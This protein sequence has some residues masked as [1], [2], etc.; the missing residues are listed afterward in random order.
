MNP[1]RT[2]FAT[3]SLF[4]ASICFAQNQK[5]EATSLLGQPLYRKEFAD[6]ELIKLSANLAEAQSNYRVAPDSANNVIW[7]GRRLG[8]VWCFREAITA[9]SDGIAKHPENPRLYRHRGH[10]YIT[11]R[12]FDNAIADLEKASKLI[13]NLPDEV[14]PDGAPNQ[15][16]IPRSTLHSNIWYHL[17]LACY[18]KGDF[19][20]AQ[21]AYSAGMKFAEVNDD[22][23]VATTHWLY[24]TLRRL[25]RMEEA[26]KILIPI[27]DQ[28][29]ILENEHYHKLLLMYKEALSPGSIL[30]LDSSSDI[31]LATIG[32]GVGNWYFYNGHQEKAMEIFEKIAA[33][34]N[35]PAFGFI[36]AEAEL[37]RAKQKK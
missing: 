20:N 9:F 25:G 6:I 19:E 5:S 18:L 22:M 7:L 16:N 36:A 4:L 14:E 27:R 37:A 29:E 30:N 8:Y 26:Q 3:L 1:T 34:E 12:E 11:V 28:M 10:R 35:W 21:R 2:Y 24:M 32:Y 31:E 33:S 13:A 17:G 15:H 23:L